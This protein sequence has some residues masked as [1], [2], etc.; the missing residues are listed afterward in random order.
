MDEERHGGHGGH[1]G[2]ARAGGQDG[3]LGDGDDDVEM[4]RWSEE[5]RGGRRE[6]RELS[7][8]T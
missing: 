1:G 7:W 8:A 5:P 6:V 3:G 2:D 4:L